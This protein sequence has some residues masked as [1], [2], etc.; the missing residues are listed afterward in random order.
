VCGRSCRPFIRLFNN[1]GST[2]EV[3]P[4]LR[5]SNEI[6]DIRFEDSMATELN[7]AFSGD[8]PYENGY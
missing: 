5:I 4:M 8:Q 6:Q 2:S 1:A 7:E 3:T